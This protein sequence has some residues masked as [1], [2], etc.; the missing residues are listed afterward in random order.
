MRI[1]LRGETI[2]IFC[3]NSNLQDSTPSEK[4]LE[5]FAVYCAQL[6]VAPRTL[7]GIRHEC[8][9]A[10]RGDVLKKHSSSRCLSSWYQ[11]SAC[12]NLTRSAGFGYAADYGYLCKVSSVLHSKDTN[13][14]EAMLWAVLCTGFHG[15]L[16]SQSLW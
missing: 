8:L 12:H 1:C 15:A 6:R 13:R 16:R 10:G 2:Q 3:A 5:L 9:V 7:W 4:A 11:K 14:M